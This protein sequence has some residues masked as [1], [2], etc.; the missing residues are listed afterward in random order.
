MP[1]NKEYGTKLISGSQIFTQPA[2]LLKQSIGVYA[3]SGSSSNF[4]SSGRFA[5]TQ[6]LGL[7]K[8]HVIQWH[9]IIRE[10]IEGGNGLSKRL[11]PTS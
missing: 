10:S 4:L 3:L 11:N 1:V 6:P 2:E 9:T 8:P 7:T 5:H